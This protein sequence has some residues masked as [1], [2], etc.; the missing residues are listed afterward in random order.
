MS[1]ARNKCR[2]YL[3]QQASPTAPYF[4]ES[5]FIETCKKLVDF[6]A[7]TLQFSIPLRRL[8]VPYNNIMSY[9]HPFEETRT[10][11]QL[12]LEPF[13]GPGT[14]LLG[15]EQRAQNLHSSLRFRP[16]ENLAEIAAEGKGDSVGQEARHERGGQGA[17]VDLLE[18]D[19]ENLGLV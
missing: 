6:E 1:R 12:S 5:T 13:L 17:G 14:T 7:V 9:V 19:L 8:R 11:T 2:I 15:D 3:R 18:G 4:D 10:R 16:R